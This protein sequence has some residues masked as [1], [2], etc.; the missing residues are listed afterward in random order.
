M[1]SRKRTPLS[2]VRVATILAQRRRG[3]DADCVEEVRNLRSK[4]RAGARKLRE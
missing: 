4:M 3:V 2:Q 1:A